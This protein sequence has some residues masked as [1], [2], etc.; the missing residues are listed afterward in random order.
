MKPWECRPRM[1]LIF[2]GSEYRVALVRQSSHRARRDGLHVPLFG[3]AFTPQP[4]L[5]NNAH[6]LPC[7]DWKPPMRGQ[8]S[9]LLS[10]NQVA[11]T[12]GH[13]IVSHCSRPAA[14]NCC[15]RRIVQLR[16]MQNIQGRVI[17]LCCR[18]TDACANRFAFRPLIDFRRAVVEAVC[19]M[20]PETRRPINPSANWTSNSRGNVLPV[21]R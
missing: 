1:G 21:A 5:P 2:F 13:F 14:T 4:Q 18:T 11:L 19:R 9:A 20:M 7:I 17:E 16:Q 10:R 12:S 6:C 3:A 8:P 15:F